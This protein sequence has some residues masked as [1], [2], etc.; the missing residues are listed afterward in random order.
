MIF[1]ILLSMVV[2]AKGCEYRPGFR[3][4]RSHLHFVGWMLYELQAIPRNQNKLR[5]SICR[6]N[7]VRS[8]ITNVIYQG[9]WLESRYPVYIPIFTSLLLFVFY[10][11]RN[12]S[13]RPL[14]TKHTLQKQLVYIVPTICL[15]ACCRKKTRH[16]CFPFAKT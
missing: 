14:R 10:T 13:P 2:L 1:F 12:E 15:Q 3:V 5:R 16:N 11:N 6:N 7:T 4:S 8:L 9:D